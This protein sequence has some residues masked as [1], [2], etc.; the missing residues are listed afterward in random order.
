MENLYQ[1]PV[2]LNLKKETIARLDSQE[3]QSFVG[4]GDEE[5]ISVN[6]GCGGKPKNTSGNNFYINLLTP[7]SSFLFVD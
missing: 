1:K 4:K 5:P 6:D 2:N 7:F 3:A